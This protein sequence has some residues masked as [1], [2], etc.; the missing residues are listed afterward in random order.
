MRR[1]CKLNKDEEKECT[2]LVYNGRAKPSGGVMICDIFDEP[3]A[4]M[5]K[6]PLEEHNERS[7]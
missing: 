7:L 5:K 1:P 4:K 3:V 2:A 6:C